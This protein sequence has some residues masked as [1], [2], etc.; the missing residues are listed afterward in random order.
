MNHNTPQ[1]EKPYGYDVEIQLNAGRGIIKKH[2][3]GSEATVRRKSMLTRCAQSVVSMTPYTRQQ[4]VAVY[5]DPKV[6]L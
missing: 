3:T 4:W 5:G 6:R 2:F 1:D